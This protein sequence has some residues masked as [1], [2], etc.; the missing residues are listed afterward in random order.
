MNKLLAL[1]CFCSVNV[2][3]FSDVLCKFQG[4]LLV[5]L[6]GSVFCGERNVK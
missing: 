6:G 5:C 3:N 4:Y 2:L 1:V